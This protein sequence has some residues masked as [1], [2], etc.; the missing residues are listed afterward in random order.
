MYQIS[1]TTKFEKDLVKCIKQGLAIANLEDVVELLEEN[2]FLPKKYK[3]HTLHGN[4]VGHWECHIEPDWLLIWLPF[5]KE[6]EIR[7]VRTGSHSEL[8]G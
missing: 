4:W 8:Y 5:K 6:K 2:G 1:T 7:L 3:P